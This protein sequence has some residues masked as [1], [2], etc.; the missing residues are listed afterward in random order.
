MIFQVSALPKPIWNPLDNGLW[1]V[2]DTV[3]R[4]GLIFNRFWAPKTGSKSFRNR[5]WPPCKLH[6][7]IKSFYQCQTA[8][9]TI[10]DTMLFSKRIREIYYSPLWRP[11]YCLLY[12][13]PETH[14][15]HV[16][17]NAVLQSNSPESWQAPEG[18]KKAQLTCFDNQNDTIHTTII[19][20]H[21]TRQ[22]N[23]CYFNGRIVYGE[24]DTIHIT[25]MVL[26]SSRQCNVCNFNGSMVGWYNTY[27]FHGLAKHK[28]TQ[29]MRLQW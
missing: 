10:S 1:I 29:R 28:A 17:V 19:V 2:L 18:K 5:V 4:F 9:Y 24:Y 16:R 26:Q 13:G 22:H 11:L 27:R 15:F 14:S 21:S 6:T 7:T 23:A 12:T 20:S 3:P 8:P 25:I